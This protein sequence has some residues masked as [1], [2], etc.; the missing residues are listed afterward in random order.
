MMEM[1]DFWLQT[2]IFWQIQAQDIFETSSKILKDSKTHDII[3]S[4]KH[5]TSAKIL[6]CCLWETSEI[7]KSSHLWFFTLLSLASLYTLGAV[8]VLFPTPQS[9]LLNLGAS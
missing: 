6:I 3:G 5:E 7:L 2:L 4:E 9:D 8:F 1:N